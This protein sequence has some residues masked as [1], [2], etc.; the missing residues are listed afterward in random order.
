[1]PQC[2]LIVQFKNV[3]FRVFASNEDLT[4]ILNF[5]ASKL[6]LLSYFVE[7]ALPYVRHIVIWWLFLDSK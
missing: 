3:F 6:A 4:T 2:L 7:N 1:M 5:L